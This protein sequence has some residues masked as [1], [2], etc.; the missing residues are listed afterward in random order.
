MKMISYAGNR[1]DVMLS[2]LFPEQSGGFYIDVG[3]GHPLQ[4]SVTKHFYERG[5]SGINIEPAI[6]PF[7]EL[8]KDRPRDVNLNV[9]IAETEGAAVFYE[10][11]PEYAGWAT[12]SRQEAERHLA[13]D[14]VAFTERTVPVT[15]LARVCE[16]HVWGPIDF[17]SVDVEGLEQQV[18]L[19]ADFERWRPR[20]CVIE[21]TVP[22]T[23]IPTHEKWEGMLLDAGYRFGYFDGLNR[24]YVRAEDSELLEAFST[25]VNCFDDF[26]PYEY[27]WQM[28]F[29]ARQ[30]A[31]SRV[32]REGSDV[33][34]AAAASH[35]EELAGE[36]QQLRARL[37]ELAAE[38]PVHQ[39]GD[40]GPMAVAVARRLSRA[41]TRFPRVAEVAR[42]G[43]RL[44]LRAKRRLDAR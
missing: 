22:N 28:Q 44:A 23:T 24:F 9:A 35:P 16:E 2:R 20:I 33:A 43:A 40:P 25:P 41:A 37:D 11:P 3:A 29:Y 1:E 13:N 5:W 17:L 14:G 36:V 21:A 7:K 15:T 27:L 8:T 10:F 12:V 31:A 39:A 4:F 26:E 34:A 42:M 6:G 18:L 30:L 32:L 19:G 38:G